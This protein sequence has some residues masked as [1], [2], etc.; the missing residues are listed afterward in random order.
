MYFDGSMMVQG[1]RAVVILISPWG[2]KMSY[3]LQI[4]FPD[5]NNMEKY[6]A[7]LHGLWIASSM[8]IRCL[9]C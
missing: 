1:M 5:S 3:I 2:D 6:E 8:G 4:H 9:I 7:L